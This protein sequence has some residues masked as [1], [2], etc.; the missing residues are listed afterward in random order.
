MGR[1]PSGPLLAQREAMKAE[2]PMP[3]EKPEEPQATL[4]G[5]PP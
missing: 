2:K 1:Q 4:S 5:D 3:L